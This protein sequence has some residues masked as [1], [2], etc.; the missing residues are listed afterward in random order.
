ME[1]DYTDMEIWIRAEVDDSQILRMPLER[2]KQTVTL[3]RLMPSE[4]RRRIRFYKET[5]AFG[6]EPDSVLLFHGIN[7]DGELYDISPRKRKIEFIGDSVTSG[8]GVA[9]PQSLKGWLSMVFSTESHY[10]VEAARLLDAD[11]RL[12]SQSGWGVKYSWDNNPFHAMPLYYKEVCSIVDSERF[13]SLGGHKENDFDSWKPDVVV[14]HLGNNDA[15]GA[16]EKPYVDPDTGKS[17]KVTANPDGTLSTESSEEIASAVYNFLKVLRA[18][19]PSAKLV[20][21]YGM[22]D[23]KAEDA[24]KTGV[25]RYNS[26]TGDD[27]E[28]IRIPRALEED[29]GSNFHPGKRA[30]LK[31]AKFLAK[32]LM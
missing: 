21:I 15:F 28:Y 1:C 2:G 11:F 16:F 17:Y 6:N 12:L 31:L 26:E 20:W 5:Q 27:A 7:C 10:A 29:N 4:G 30:H 9:G 18:C 23:L 24:L 3:F 25:E 32:E 8:E 14:V 13:R 19:N 22:F